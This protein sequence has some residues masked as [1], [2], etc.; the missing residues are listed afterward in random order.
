MNTNR[1]TL[2]H[3]EAR[4][5]LAGGILPDPRERAIA[6][7]LFADGMDADTALRQARII[8]AADSV[9][10]PTP[11]FLDLFRDAATDILF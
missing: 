11:D 2:L 7:R 8:A 1:N 10:A 5:L 9:P 3:A 4:V 6:E